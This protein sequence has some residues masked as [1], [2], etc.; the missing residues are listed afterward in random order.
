MRLFAIGDIHGCLH[1][2]DELLAEIKPTKDDTLLTLG[3]IIDRGP[4]SKGVIQRLLQLKTKTN[5]LM[6][7]GNHEQLMLDARFDEVAYVTW[8]HNGGME[9][10]R[11]YS[12]SATL[13]DIPLE[14]IA[15]LEKP[16][17][18]YWETSTHIFVHGGLDPHTDLPLQSKDTM[19]WSRFAHPAPHKTGKIMVC[20]HTPQI[21]G[22][23]NHQGHAICLDTATFTGGPL[24]A[25][26]VRTG[27]VWQ[28]FSMGGVLKTK[29]ADY[30]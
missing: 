13:L 27:D 30:R 7:R 25:L 14:H 21:S 10:L 15:F 5:L 3:D 20:G 12:P 24:T 4:D 18:F 2:L 22:R 11:S 8:M 26:E 19:L 6:L 29:L 1:E 17:L 23:P 9:M 28:A 16:P